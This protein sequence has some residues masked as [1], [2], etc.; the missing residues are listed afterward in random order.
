MKRLFR[1]AFSL[2]QLLGA[3]ISL[4]FL[5]WFISGLVFIYFPF[6]SVEQD[7]F[8][9]QQEKLPKTI[10]AIDS[11]LVEYK[12]YPMRLFQQQGQTLLEVAGDDW[13]DVVCLDNQ[14]VLEVEVLPLAKRW[15]QAPILKIDTLTER[16]Q[17]IM[18][19]SYERKMPIYKFYF[20]NEEKHQ[21]YISEVTREV[22]QFTTQK[23]RFWAYLGAIPHKLYFPFLRK[24]TDTW[25]LTL[26][27]LGAIA[28]VAVLLGMFIGIKL[29]FKKTNKKGIGSPYKKRWYFWHHIAGLVF[30]VFL[31]SWAFSGA[32]SL[33]R[34]PQWAVKTHENY[35]NKQSE[36]LYP[37][38]PQSAYKLDCREILKALPNVKEIVWSQFYQTPIYEV[39]SENNWRYFDAS[40]TTLQELAIPKN[41]IENIIKEIHENT[42]F[43]VSLLTEYD[44]YYMSLDDS[45]PLPVYKVEVEDKDKSL[46]YFNPQTGAYRYLNA[47]RQAKK[48]VFSALH[49]FNI[50]FFAGRYALWTVAMWIL[51]LGGIV[52]SASGVYLTWKLLG[53]KF[54]K[55]KIKK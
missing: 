23:Q 31:L 16:E 37:Y 39:L 1:I 35:R 54:R 50:P 33:Q 38:L 9:K 7:D 36:V 25:I 5:M 20:D 42:P 19:S 14:E 29:F 48:W 13:E 34:I 30:G 26:T 32:M 10:P 53:R 22:E 55:L 11:L 8:Y 21:L 52:V 6:P 28:F 40:K 41:A 27:V 17:W 51:C 24:H 15:V 44:S 2:H 49:Y 47:S 45:K 18:F 3:F 43:T 12:A 46:Y 4:F